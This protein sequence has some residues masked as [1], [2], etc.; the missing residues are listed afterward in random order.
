MTTKSFKLK[1][2]DITASRRLLDFNIIEIV[3]TE[4]RVFSSTIFI[5]H[6]SENKDGLFAFWYEKAMY[7]I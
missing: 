3:L 7:L 6:E 5:F 1:Y 4:S 2:T